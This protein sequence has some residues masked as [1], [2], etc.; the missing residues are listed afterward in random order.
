MGRIDN[1]KLIYISA[2][3]VVILGVLFALLLGSKTQKLLGAGDNVEVIHS[4]GHAYVV[5][6]S[7]RAHWRKIRGHNSIYSQSAHDSGYKPASSYVNNYEPSSADNAPLVNSVKFIGKKQKLKPGSK[8]KKAEK[9]AGRASRFD[10]FGSSPDD[11]TGSGAKVPSLASAAAGGAPAKAKNPQDDDQNIDTVEY[12]NAP[13][14]VNE[15]QQAVDKLVDSYKVQKVSGGVFYTVVG[16][17]TEDTRTNIREWSIDAL[18][19]T[20]SVQSFGMLTGMKHDD[21]DP[22]LRTE[23]G[24][25]VATYAASNRLGFVVN[26]MNA[27]TA[28]EQITVEALRT[29]TASTQRYGGDVQQQSDGSTKNVA[30]D[31]AVEPRY[32]RALQIIDQNGYTNSSDVTVKS[33]A[34]KTVA[35]I[36]KLITI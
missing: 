32:E 36:N 19:Q 14:F 13:I 22:N 11:L 17:M 5:G 23:A 12:W 35:A 20:P 21:V 16:Q 28:N 34:T 7:P 24:E 10:G 18:G 2:A 26:A 8:K 4:A 33:E 29:L 30:L 9:V 3:A 31:A 27:Q 15:D 25:K 6:D 1:S